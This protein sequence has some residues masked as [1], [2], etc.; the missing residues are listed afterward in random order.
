MER[1]NSPGPSL[2]PLL[3]CLARYERRFVLDYLRA[4]DGSA[5]VDVLGGALLDHEETDPALSEGSSTR[6]AR[7][8]S[9]SSRA[10]AS[11]K[12]RGTR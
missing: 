5:T 4:H 10:V 7:A 1:S 8:T 12:S 9:H 2:D 11:S 6:S 3:D